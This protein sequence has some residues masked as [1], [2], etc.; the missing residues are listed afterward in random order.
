VQ[1]LDYLD[2]D[3]WGTVFRDVILLALIGFVAMV[4]MLLPHITTKQQ[5]SEDQKTP[6]KIYQVGQ[7]ILG[8]AQELFP[9]GA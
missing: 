9:S 6:Q 2:D 4:I 1:G 7:R 8:A 5:D 3:S